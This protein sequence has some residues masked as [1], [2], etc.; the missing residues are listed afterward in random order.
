MIPAL[1]VLFLATAVLTQTPAI[2]RGLARQYFEEAAEIAGRDDGNLWGFSLAGPLMFGDA[3]SRELVANQADANGRLQEVDG[4]FVGELDPGQGV[5][6]TAIHWSG[7]YWTTLIWPL[8]QEELARK[9]LLAHEMYHRIQ[10]DLDLQGGNPQN[11]QLDTKD[12][13]ILA[14][15]EWRALQT[16]VTSVGEDRELA[17]QDALAFR[18]RRRELFPEAAAT[19]QLL[20]LN[21]GLAEYTGT[22]LCGSD[23]KTR[24]RRIAAA[25]SSQERRKNYVRNFAYAVGPAYGFLLDEVSSNWR[26]ELHPKSDFGHLLAEHYGVTESDDLAGDV[27][28]CM[29]DYGGEEVVREET[30]R[31]EARDQRIATYRARYVDGPVLR[32]E[33]DPSLRYS[34]NPNHLETWEPHGTV[35]GTFHLTA[36]FGVLE[37]RSGVLVEFDEGAIQAAIVPAPASAAQLSGPGWKLTLADGWSMVA[38]ARAGDFNLAAP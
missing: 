18:E 30:Q 29:E 26:E 25:L 9:Q 14:R 4:V 2:D 31:A 6:N 36:E 15:L 33:P 38:G 19:E 8:P 17:V 28:L 34:F 12:G 5:A 32:I 35:Y 27:E 11:P 1:P 24:I 3:A 16:A 23:R 7:T 20:E 13:R 22:V 37:V 10:R 21:E